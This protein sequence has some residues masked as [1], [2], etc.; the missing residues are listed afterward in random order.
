MPQPLELRMGQVVTLK[1]VHPCGSAQ[2]EV[3]RLGM[4]VRLRCQGCNRY[5]LFPPEPAG[6]QG[7]ERRPARFVGPSSPLAEAPRR[8]D[9]APTAT[10]GRVAHPKGR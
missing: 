8:P 6:A 7:A 10:A 1:K 4:D 5:V 2:W 3:V 9:R